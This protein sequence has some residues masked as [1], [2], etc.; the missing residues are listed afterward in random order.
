[1]AAMLLAMLLPACCLGCGVVLRSERTPEV[2]IACA[3]ELAPL[4]QRSQAGIVASWPYAG[5]FAQALVRLKYQQ[6]GAL[7]GPLGRALAAAPE[8]S[9]AHWDLV[10]AVPMHWRRRWQRGFDHAALLLAHAVRSRA[11]APRRVAL[12][13]RTRHAPPQAE[14]SASARQDNL[15]GA[16]AVRPRMHARVAGQRVLVVDDVTTTGATLHAAAAA[17][18][19]A[20]AAEVGRLA[21]LRTIAG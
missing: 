20:G 6:D 21:L 7:A 10:C 18:D 9:R 15:V 14:L 16:F 17:L 2:C 4:V 3:S 5:A 12:L 11:D 1:M 13:Q 19:R 8:L